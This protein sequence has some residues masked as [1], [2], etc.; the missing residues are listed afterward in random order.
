MAKN[1]RKYV[2]PKQQKCDASSISN[3]RGMARKAKT[4]SN[5]I[6][7]QMLEKETVILTKE[8][9]NRYSEQ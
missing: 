6:D 4:K 2:S 5:K 9:I 3:K 8:Q 1:I 7:R